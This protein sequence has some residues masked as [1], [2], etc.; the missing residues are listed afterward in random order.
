MP[1]SGTWADTLSSSE[2]WSSGTMHQAGV[3]LHLLSETPHVGP[4]VRKHHSWRSL[5]STRSSAVT[6][7]TTF[8]VLIS[9]CDQFIFPWWLTLTLTQFWLSLFCP[10]F[11]NFLFLMEKTFFHLTRA[12]FPVTFQRGFVVSTLYSCHVWHHRYPSL[13]PE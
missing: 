11:H 13:T 12:C 10:I 6:S 9:A 2:L 5:T 1:S 3:L 4:V 7:M 8:G